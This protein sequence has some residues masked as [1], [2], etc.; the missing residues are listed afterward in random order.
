MS[1]DIYQTKIILTHKEIERIFKFSRKNKTDNVIVIHTNW[2]E[3]AR[4]D[5]EDTI[6][7][8]FQSDWL[9]NTR[10]KKQ[11]VTDYTVR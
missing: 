2:G 6:K 10:C 4:G 9:Q 3:L 7:V 8:V 11:D 1:S 5:Y